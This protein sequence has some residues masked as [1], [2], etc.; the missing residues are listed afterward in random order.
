MLSMKTTTKTATLR[1]GD[2]MVIKATGERVELVCEPDSDPTCSV[3]VLF[4][5]DR[6]RDAHIL[7]SEL[8]SVELH[9]AATVMGE[10]H[11]EESGS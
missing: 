11:A 7:P 10:M 1:C 4:V 9:Q 3:W 2:E 5:N 8:S 6:D